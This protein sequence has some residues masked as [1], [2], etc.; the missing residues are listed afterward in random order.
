MGQWLEQKY[1]ADSMALIV[2]EGGGLSEVF[3]QMFALPAVA[4][5]GY[6]DVELQVQT[7]GG[8]SSVPRESPT[9]NSADRSRAHGYWVRCARLG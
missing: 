9:S 1:G 5:K 8:H 3:G 6:L 2:D 7:L 4:E